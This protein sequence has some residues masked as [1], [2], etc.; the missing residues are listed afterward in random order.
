MLPNLYIL[1]YEC[2]FLVLSI[3]IIINII[4]TIIEMMIKLQDQPFK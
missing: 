4:V 1:F 2:K 3:F